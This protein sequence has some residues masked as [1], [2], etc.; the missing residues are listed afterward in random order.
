LGLMDVQY[1]VQYQG[2]G[3][4]PHRL[5]FPPRHVSL[6]CLQIPTMT[7]PRPD[8]SLLEISQGWDAERRMGGWAPSFPYIIVRLPPSIK[9]YDSPF[10]SPIGGESRILASLSL[11]LCFVR[12]L[13]SSSSPLGQTCDLRE[14][15]STGVVVVC[16]VCT[17]RVNFNLGSFSFGKNISLKSFTFRV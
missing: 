14:H 3:T 9:L 5:L 7:L 11:S 1:T 2:S 17:G 12:V 6:C 10:S 16:T 8:Q 13:P 15:L 4:V